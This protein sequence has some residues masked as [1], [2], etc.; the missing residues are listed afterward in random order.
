MAA[1]EPTPVSTIDSPTIDHSTEDPF[2]AQ[3]EGDDP[4]AKGVGQPLEPNA[5]KDG[6][7]SPPTSPP[8]RERRMSKEWDAS[9]VPPSQ[10]QKRKGSIYATPSSR[11]SHHGGGDRDK[12]YFEKLKEKVGYILPPRGC[13]VWYKDG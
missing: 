10:F 11:D 8:A 3:R 5:I 4:F 9:K 13:I 6:S 1:V 12:A 2:A 7:L